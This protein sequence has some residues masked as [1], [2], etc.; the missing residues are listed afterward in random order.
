MDL[1]APAFKYLLLI[2]LVIGWLYYRMNRS[3]RRRQSR[4]GRHLWRESLRERR[5]ERMQGAESWDERRRRKAEVDPERRI[6]N[7]FLTAGRGPESADGPP[8]G[9]ATTRGKEPAE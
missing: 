6:A 9:E 4:H 2:V 5:A 7:R 1:S 8:D 3:L